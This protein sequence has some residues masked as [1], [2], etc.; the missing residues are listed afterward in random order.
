M[1]GK[2]RVES[3]GESRFLNT[4]AWI[5]LIGVALCYYLSRQGAD[6]ESIGRYLYIMGIRENPGVVFNPWVR[7][8]SSICYAPVWFLAD[9]IEAGF[10]TVQLFSMLFSL[11]AVL[12]VQKT[13]RKLEIRFTW[14]VP[15]LFLTSPFFMRS[16]YHMWVETLFLLFLSIGIFYWVSGRE[17][18]AIFWIALLPLARVEFLG[19]LIPFALY[20]TATRRYRGALF[21]LLPYGVLYLL[22]IIHTG[23]LLWIIHTK[24]NYRGDPAYPSMDFLESISYYVKSGLIVHGAMLVPLALCRMITKRDFLSWAT[25]SFF[26]LQLALLILLKTYLWG[27]Y[28]MVLSP[29]IILLALGLITNMA[30]SRGKRWRAL[31]VPVLVLLGLS[32]VIQVAK[33]YP[34][35]EITPSRYNER[36]T[37][38][39]E[40]VMDCRTQYGEA[41]EEDVLYA[42]PWVAF[43]LG[44]AK[45]NDPYVTNMTTD[46]IENAEEGT[47]ILWDSNLSPRLIFQVPLDFLLNRPGIELLRM[48]TSESIS[49]YLFE[50]VY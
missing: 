1:N 31:V 29:L 46:I 4:M 23:D 37:A 32:M 9:D 5:A 47:M 19:V 11:L 33:R 36:A 34:Y 12:F 35:P 43:F 40:F 13:A 3:I 7:L 17:M 26:V 30:R 18:L 48:T 50:K 2:D 44:K 14:L 42:N 24:G 22:T 8:I 38:I 21:L 15:F 45:P 27:R 39:K 49:L 16:T 10:R 20:L 41:F 25:A 6:G 28:Y